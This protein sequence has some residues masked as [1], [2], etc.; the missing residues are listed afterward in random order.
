LIRA[1]PSKNP[2]TVITFSLVSYVISYISYNFLV[3]IITI[4]LLFLII[5]IVNLTGGDLRLIGI[6]NI[7]YLFK[8]LIVQKGHVVSKQDIA[9][10]FAI[11]SFVFMLL[12]IITSKL[13]SSITKHKVIVNPKLRIII[14][15]LI[16]TTL[17][18]L[19]QIS[20]LLPDAPKGADTLRPVLL[21]F[22]IT[23]LVIYV[24]YASLIVLQESIRG[25]VRG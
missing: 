10:F 7:A 17:M 4:C 15:I 8:S 3:G 5:A 12:G 23:A 13:W 14:G 19:A 6:N 11:M 16:I 24:F 1:M 2:F 18:L 22:W 20:T 9:R 25:Y 21:L